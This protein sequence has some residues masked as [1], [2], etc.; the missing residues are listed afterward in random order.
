MKIKV[1]LLALFTA[2][3]GVS[4]ALAAAP[5]AVG[6]T[7]TTTVAATTTAATTT[8]EEKGEGKHHAKHKG[9]SEA[10]ASACKPRRKIELKGVYVAAGAGGFAM[11]VTGGNKPAKPWK[12]KQAT[13]LVDDKSKFNGKKHSLAELVAGDRVHVQGYACK[14]DLAAGTV[15]ARK[16]KSKGPKKDEAG[17]TT[18]A[19]STAAVTTTAP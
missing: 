5:A 1:L 3:L 10:K 19:A 4:M 15:L 2:G 6:E 18:T 14:S 13:I 7:G 16:V 9:K 8:S 12:G 17:E 11:T